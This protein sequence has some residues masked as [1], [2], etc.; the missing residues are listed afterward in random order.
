M[1]DGR[2][3]MTAGD[4]WKTAQK[5]PSGIVSFKTHASE[6]K[7]GAVSKNANRHWLVGTHGVGLG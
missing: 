2:C 3:H 5:E 4:W 6:V 1:P 7:L